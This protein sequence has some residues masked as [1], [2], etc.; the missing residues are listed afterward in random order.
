MIIYIT[1]TIFPSD[2]L[3]AN[4]TDLENWKREFWSIRDKNGNMKYK[5]F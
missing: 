1:H 5:D 3:E 2:S 4:I